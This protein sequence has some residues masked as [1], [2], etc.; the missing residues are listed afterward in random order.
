MAVF[1]RAGR[2]I[3]LVGAMSASDGQALHRVMMDGDK[4]AGEE[5]YLIGERV[6]DVRVG[7]DGAIY[8]TT[9][10]RSGDPV[11]KVLRLTP[12]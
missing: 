2:A 9:E 8:V 6:R 10:E 3:L 4:P 7:P 1:F 12:Q 5:R 11:G